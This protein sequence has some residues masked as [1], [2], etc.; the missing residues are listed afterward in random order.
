MSKTIYFIVPYPLGQ[1]PSQRFRFEQ[2]FPALREQGY[3]LEIHPFLD[4]KTW[5][6]VH[7]EGG[8]IQK[9]VGIFKSFLRRIRLLFRVSKS[10]ILFIHREAAQVGP[11]FL[12]WILVKLLHKKYIYDFDDAIWLPNYSESNA[13]FHRL[14]AYWKVKFLF[15]WAEKIVAGNAYL[16]SYAQQFNPNVQVIPTTIDTIHHH[17]MVCN[18]ANEIPIIGWTGSH[19]TLHYLEM[20]VPI[21]AELEKVY[22]FHFL[23]I[24]N[25]KPNFNL[26]SLRYIPWNKDT[27]IH[28]LSQITIGIMPLQNDPWSAGKCGFKGLQYMALEIATILSPVGV[29]KT[30]VT[31]NHD[32]FFA[33]TAEEWKEKLINLLENP[34][35][36]NR[37]GKNARITIENRY[38][39]VSQ[40]TTF[41]SLFETE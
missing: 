1:A 19:T 29:N 21:I 15:K 27:E 25:E 23:V 24:C 39:V 2:Y 8:F 35:L 26:Q 38:S 14:K 22:T 32:G 6:I 13:R 33:D 37:I 16:A 17:N 7:K 36:R 41:L 9:A 31:E 5:G 4:E 12:E 40:T 34:P 18:H 28:D 3:N 11:P 30:I 10:D 20:I